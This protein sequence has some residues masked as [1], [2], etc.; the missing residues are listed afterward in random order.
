MIEIFSL[1]GGGLMR[2]APMLLSFF[3]EG[4]DLKYELLRMEKEAELERLR[5]ELRKEEIAAV[6]N[7]AEQGAWAA[8]VIDAL[9]SAIPPALTDS[10]SR[11]LN[12]FNII[13]TSVRSILTYW[14]CLV[15]YT[16]YKVFVILAAVQEHLPAG[17]MAD[18]LCTEFDKAVVASIIGFWFVDRA[19]R[20]KGVSK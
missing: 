12:F 11:W 10:G 9:K 6:A 8:A 7:A 18:V 15:L 17:K 1:L 13:N 3:K 14:W 5:A 2:L 19:L 20:Q 4:R 16:A